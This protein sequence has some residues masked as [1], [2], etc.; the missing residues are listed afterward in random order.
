MLFDRIALEKH[1]CVATTAQ[2]IQNSKHWILTSS[3][4]GPQQPQSTT[5]LCS[6][7]KGM[8]TIARRAPGK[9]S[10]RLQNHPSQSTSRQRKEQQ[11]EGIEEFDYTVHSGPENRLEVGSTKG[12]GETCRQLRHRIGIEPIGRRAIGILSILHGLTIREFFSELGPVSVAWRT[13]SSQPTEV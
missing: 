9:D 13:T 12:R 6:S 7:E 3:A 8:Q 10:A 2:R 1:V 5:R 4:E 11:F